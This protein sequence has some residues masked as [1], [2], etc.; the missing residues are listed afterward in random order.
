MAEALRWYLATLL[1]NVACYVAGE[2]LVTVADKTR[3]F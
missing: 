1:E 2:D 3:W